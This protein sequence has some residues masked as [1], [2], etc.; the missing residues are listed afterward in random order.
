MVGCVA[1]WA[2]FQEDKKREVM[3]TP[4]LGVCIPVTYS[5]VR[6]GDTPEFR[7]RTGMAIAIRPLDFSKPETN[8]PG[9]PEATARLHQLL[10]EAKEIRLFFP[11]ASTGKDPILDVFDIIRSVFTFDRVLAH[12]YVDGELVQ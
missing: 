2:A 1:I 10:S 8:E 12:V 5:R 9:G 4:D 7:L 3:S 6:D 11:L